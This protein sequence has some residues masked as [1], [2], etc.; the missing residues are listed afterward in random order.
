M[1]LSPEAKE[2]KSHKSFLQDF[3]NNTDVSSMQHRKGVKVTT[4]PPLS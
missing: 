1:K 4:F 2:S 3:D